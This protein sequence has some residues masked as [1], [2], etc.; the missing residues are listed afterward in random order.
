MDHIQVSFTDLQAEQKEILIARLT[1]AG[2]DGFEEH[3]NGLDAFISKDRFDKTVLNEIAFKYQLPFQLQEIKETNW[4]ERWETS[5][6]P[7]IVDDYVAVRADFHAPVLNCKHEIIITPKMS[8]G[9]GHH[10]TTYLMIRLM[11]EL[12]F[13]GK[14]V[15]DFGTGTGILAI[16]AEK[17]NAENIVAIDIDDWSIEN[18]KENIAKNNSRKIILLKA[19]HP[20][21]QKKADI[22]LANINRNVILE[23]FDTLSGLLNKN[24]NML[25]SG[26]LTSDF[27]AIISEAGKKRLR[28]QQK[29]TRDN[30]L[31]MQLLN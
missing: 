24:G 10:A 2:F 17:E 16:L 15:L 28:L 9:T 23:N 14:Q 22:I 4:N 8:F 29:F 26:F 12:N 18:A 20:V 21:L 3:E 6:Q 30:W 27:E 25:L 19:D 11:R 31:C 13:A 1:D 5:F 7:V